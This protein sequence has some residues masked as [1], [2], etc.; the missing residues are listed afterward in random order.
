MDKIASHRQYFEQSFE[1]QRLPSQQLSGI[2]FDSCEFN[3]CDFS[4]VVFT[5]CKFIDC[6]FNHCNLSLM[7]VP[8]SQFVEV[9]FVEC[10]LVGVDW[11]RAAWPS[12]QL[13][14]ELQFKQCILND[15]SFF[16]LTL[17]GLVLERCKLHEVDWREGDFSNSVM[18]DCDF[19]NSL[20]MRTKLNKVDF[21]DSCHFS[22][23]VLENTLTK[24]RFSRYEALSLLESLGIELVD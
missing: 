9:A 15:A 20:F 8:Y 12:F 5:R 3:K 4:S 2:E 19:S 17:N 10:K 1:Q 6:T 23:N 11:T 22:I 21:T 18:T 13:H 24:A 14:A 7:Q 16:G